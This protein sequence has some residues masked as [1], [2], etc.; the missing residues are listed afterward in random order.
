M[1]HKPSTNN[2][3]DRIYER[4]TL[5]QQLKSF[6]AKCTRRNI[7]RSTSREESTT[8]TND[9]LRNQEIAK[10]N[11][12]TEKAKQVNETVSINIQHRSYS[13]KSSKKFKLNEKF[14]KV[15]KTD[16][17]SSKQDVK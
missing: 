17:E 9:Q 11:P 7:S 13:S 12:R 6:S 4:P 2:T 8:K 16:Q 3:T 5:Q 1:N 15:Q 10:L 14:K